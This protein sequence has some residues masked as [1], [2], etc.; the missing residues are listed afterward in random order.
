MWG[1]AVIFNDFYFNLRPV[2][3]FKDIS[4]LSGPG[5]LSYQDVRGWQGYLSN[6]I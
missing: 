4:P 3:K 2:L 1:D 6:H 5:G